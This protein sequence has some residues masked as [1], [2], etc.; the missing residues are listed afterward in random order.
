MMHHLLPLSYSVRT[1]YVIWW[2]W[3]VMNFPCLHAMETYAS[4]VAGKRDRVVPSY[5]ASPLRQNNYEGT[6]KSPTR[7]PAKKKVSSEHR[8]TSTKKK[9]RQ[10]CCGHED[11]HNIHQKILDLYINTSPQPK[12][13]NP[14]FV[15]KKNQGNPDLY[16]IAREF[17]AETTGTPCSL[18]HY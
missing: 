17:V 12:S 3:V 8:S 13:I 4:I 5:P 14:F 1:V 11:C 15:F 10:C 2:V 6:T 7:S 18:C 9:K 16:E